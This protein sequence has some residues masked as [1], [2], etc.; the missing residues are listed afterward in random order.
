MRPRRT[1]T[2]EPKKQ[3]VENILSGM[4]TPGSACRKY[5]I[6]YPVISR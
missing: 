1:F 6:A 4:L 3:I 2:T 5:N